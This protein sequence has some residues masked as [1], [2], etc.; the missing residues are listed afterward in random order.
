M[1]E[2]Q[3]MCLGWEDLLQ[4]GR[5]ATPIFLPEKCRGQRS[6][7]GYSLWGHKELDATEHT[8]IHV[9]IICFIM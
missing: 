1:Q 3:E 5:A 7:V 6:L 4:K 8:Q 2:T 9:K